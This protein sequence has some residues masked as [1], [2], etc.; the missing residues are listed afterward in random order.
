MTQASVGFHCPQCTH[1]GARRAPVL[2][3]RD[4]RLGDR[5]IVTQLLI[6]LNVLGYLA[7]LATGG[8]AFDGGGRAT[9]QGMTLG[10]GVLVSRSGPW[11]S[12]RLVGVAHG[13]WWRIITGGFL[14]SGLLHLGMNMLLLWML[15][16]QLEP[17]LGRARFAALYA[18]CLIGGSFGALWVSPTT[19]TV[20]AS[21]AVFGLMGAAVVAQRRSGIDVWHNG[22]GGLVVINLLLTFAVPGI[23]IGAHIGGL[24][25]GVL[26]GAA[27]FALDAAVRSPWVGTLAALGIAALLWIGCLV[28]AAHAVA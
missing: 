1:A 17:V 18:A 14:H 22:I 4:L 20:G 27:V 19:G 2:R 3:M 12:T 23:A 5:P 13:E 6:S 21:G 9:E 28:V 25:V 24:V 7:I 8:S 16:R 10:E 15:G 26:V 11:I